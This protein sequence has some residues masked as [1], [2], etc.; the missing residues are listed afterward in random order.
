MKN[1]LTKKRIK[2]LAP[3][4]KEILENEFL[5]EELIQNRLAL[6]IEYDMNRKFFKKVGGE[7][8]L[9][10]IIKDLEEHG[11][12]PEKASQMSPEEFANFIIEN[13]I[14][15]DK[16]ERNNENNNRK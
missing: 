5:K 10:E 4:E 9:W 6:A 7:E 11:L 2:E 13:D 16:K 1:I 12:T 8:G 3:H 14:I 15:I